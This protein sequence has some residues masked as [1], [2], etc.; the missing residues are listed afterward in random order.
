MVVGFRGTKFAVVPVETSTGNR[1][2]LTDDKGNDKGFSV[3]AM[4]GLDVKGEGISSCV[5]VNQVVAV[6]PAATTWAGKTRG[7]VC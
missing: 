3:F 7:S 4:L 5:G 2:L 1:L 6:G